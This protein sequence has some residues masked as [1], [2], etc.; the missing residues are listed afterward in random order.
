MTLA[1]LA[2]SSSFKTNIMFFIALTFLA[3]FLIEGLGTLVSV[4]GLSSLFGS[5]PIIIALAI[6]LDIGKI[7]VVTLLYSY[8]SQ[9][10][11]LMKGY[12]LVAAVVTMVIT[13][14]G[15][16]GYL[17]GEF[18]K[19]I[20]GTQESG[21]KVDVL[22]QQIAKYEERKKQIDEQIASL[23]EK[24]TVNQRIRLINAF[25][26]EQKDL[27]EK[28][29]AL[30]KQLPELQIAQIGVEAKAGPILYIAKAFDIPVE[31]AVKWVILMIIFVFD[32]LAVFLIIAGNFLLEQH[33]Q[34]KPKDVDLFA[35]DPDRGNPKVLPREKIE[36]LE[37]EAR[38]R[39]AIK[40]DDLDEQAWNTAYIKD[41]GTVIRPQM[42]EQEPV[43]EVL[44]LTVEPVEPASAF[45]FV[46]SDVVGQPINTGFSLPPQAAVDTQHITPVDYKLEQEKHEA[47]R[48]GM[49]LEEWRAF[50]L[51][52]LDRIQAGLNEIMGKL[53]REQITKSTLG[54]VKPDPTTRIN[55]MPADDSHVGDSDAKKSG[56]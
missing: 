32:P 21:L 15:A 42:P 51:A 23:P 11:K 45:E 3:A 40:V 50:Q 8:W 43:S 1:P 30:D 2:R 7:V 54:L 9:L 16:A 52:K 25:K 39:E 33:R 26:A 46:A 31:S 53:P 13:S 4:I 34:Q 36:Q 19:A 22:K 12:A 20:L 24:T 44:P 5:N 56:Y 35:D 27:Q 37:A 10:G 49:S 6:S 38:Q 47:A 29:S 28:I 17:S 41:D 48:A 14:A 18:Q 55:M